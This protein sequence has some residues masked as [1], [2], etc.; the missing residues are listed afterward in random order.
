MAS[1]KICEHEEL[2]GSFKY[3]NQELG[4]H[5][6]DEFLKIIGRQHVS[7]LAAAWVIH[8]EVQFLKIR[9]RFEDFR[10]IGWWN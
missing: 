1:Q 2:L 7:S 4:L 6:M 8:F 3:F 10:H 5:G 9:I